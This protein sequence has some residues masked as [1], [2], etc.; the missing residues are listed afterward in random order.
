VQPL[1][2]DLQLTLKLLK[3]SGWLQAPP[4][5]LGPQKR[6]TVSVIVSLGP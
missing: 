4:V 1:L 5:L 3:L 2:R 6:D